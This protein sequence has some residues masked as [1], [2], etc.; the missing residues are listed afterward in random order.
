MDSMHSRRSSKTAGGRYSHY[1]SDCRGTR[2][3]RLE[4]GPPPAHRA[5]HCV[6]IR[7]AHERGPS[8]AEPLLKR[9][10]QIEPSPTK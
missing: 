5:D 3:H 8:L 2:E 1:E 7:L 6:R 4:N 9:V 10:T